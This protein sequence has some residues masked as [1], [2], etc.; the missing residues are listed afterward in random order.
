MKPD[1]ESGETCFVIILWIGLLKV[2]LIIGLLSFRV[3]LGDSGYPTLCCVDVVISNAN[4]HR[5]LWGNIHSCCSLEN[6][7]FHTFLFYSP[8]GDPFRLDS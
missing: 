1:S 8:T 3:S 2:K 4:L 6:K 7:Y 5:G